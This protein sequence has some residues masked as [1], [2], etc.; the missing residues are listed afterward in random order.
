M[1][2]QKI[3]EQAVNEMELA[4]A[5][6]DQANL[7][8]YSARKKLE[9]IYS[10][11]SPKRAKTKFTKKQEAELLMKLNRNMLGKRGTKS[12]PQKQPI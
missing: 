5:M 11:A 12:Q 9:S 1:T 3:I 10:P 8:Y 4:K 7:R 6:I 2:H